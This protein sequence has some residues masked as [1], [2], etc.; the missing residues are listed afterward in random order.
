MN[1]YKCSRALCWHHVVFLKVQVGHLYLKCS[2]RYAVQLVIGQDE[3]PQVHQTLEVGVIQ[4]SEAV[5]V[6]VESV[7]ILE[8]SEG[9]WPDLTDGISA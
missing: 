1:L 5:G 8:I 9:I 4:D 6:Q 3:V 7:E 2:L